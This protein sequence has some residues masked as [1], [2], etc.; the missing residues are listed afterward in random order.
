MAGVCL[1]G[2]EGGGGQLLSRVRANAEMGL[3]G[4]IPLGLAC[5]GWVRWGRALMVKTCNV[6]VCFSIL[7][8]FY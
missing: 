8:L 2:W 3:S 1:W 6:E 7:S 5:L 4:V